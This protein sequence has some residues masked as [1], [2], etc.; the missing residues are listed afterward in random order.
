[1]ADTALLIARQWPEPNST[2]AGRRT[3][4]LL[5]ILQQQGYQIHLASTAEPTPFQADLSTLG[6]QTHRIALNDSSFDQWI[7]E[8]NPT[9]VVYDRFVS[10]E[11]FGWR[12]RQQIPQAMTVLDTSDLH[13]LRSAREVSVKKQQPIDLFNDIALREVAAIVRCDLTLMIS[14]VET[15]LLNTTF[16]VPQ[17]LLC[18]LPFLV[19]EDDY[20]PGGDFDSRQHLI[21][22]GGFKHE[23]NRDAARWLRDSIWPLLKPQLPKHVE[24]HV[25]GAYPDQAMQQLHN[26][27]QGFHLKGRADDALATFRQYRLNLAPLRFGAG[28]K[29]KI[30]EGWLT[31]TPTISNA[32]GAES[33]IGPLSPGYELPE[34]AQAFADLSARVYKDPDLWQ[35]LV[36]AGEQIL[37]Q[38]FRRDEHI[39]PFVQRVADVRADLTSHRHQNFWGRLLWQE[40]FRSTEFMSR[41]IE[42]KTQLKSTSTPGSTR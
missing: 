25:Y 20:Q 14:D 31:G 2:A 36:S 5:S 40:Q 13:C 6:Y 35:S 30:L 21:M 3:L 7:T 9:L 41:W 16:K 26:P 22:M 1:M 39:V 33:M 19:S 18:Y 29:G 12:I 11:Q 10:E 38:R 15:E 37:S 24:M 34:D 4:D 27:A 8:L 32:I 42:A 17:T 28:Q 23:P